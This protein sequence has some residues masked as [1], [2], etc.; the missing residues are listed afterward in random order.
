MSKYE[1]NLNERDARAEVDDPLLNK[2]DNA[3]QSCSSFDTQASRYNFWKDLYK[4]EGAYEAEINSN[5]QK[6]TNGTNSAHGHDSLQSTKQNLLKDKFRANL[7]CRVQSNIIKKVSG[8]KKRGGQA[9]VG[10]L[11]GAMAGD[12]GSATPI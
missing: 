7:V 8:S 4:G 12:D 5:A 9:G 2:L 3:A 11:S 10:G 1:R 6:A